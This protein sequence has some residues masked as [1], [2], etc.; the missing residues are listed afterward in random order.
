VSA[1]SGN[2]TPPGPSRRGEELNLRLEA[3]RA[4]LE[5]AARPSAE[6]A[7]RVL[8]ARA[9]RLALE[10]RE[11]E[12]AADRLEVVEFTLAGERYAIGS[13]HVREVCRLEDLTPLPGTPDFVLGVV[14]VR[15]EIRSVV[16][17]KR[18]FDLPDTRITELNRLILLDDGSMT[19]GVLADTV[20]GIST[21]DPA[22]IRPP[23]P[24]LTGTRGRL[25]KGVTAHRQIVI[26]AAR[27]LADPDL[28]VGYNAST[29]TGGA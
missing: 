13:G 25:L 20:T 26:D 10:P 9:R 23:P 22:D 21:L 1:R 27:L 16:D 7:D 17:L 6:D 14:N 5:A 4:A 12:S 24:T 19:F 18:V 2:D 11:S 28:I 29:E 3:A 8:D 15:G